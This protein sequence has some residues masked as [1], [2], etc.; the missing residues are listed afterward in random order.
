MKRSGFT[1]IELLVSIGI[2]MLLAGLI[3]S[4]L[5][6]ARQRA[7]TLEARRAIE[8]IQLAW[9]AFLAD[10][11]QFPFEGSGT[12]TLESDMNMLILR[13]GNRN[14][15]TSDGQAYRDLNPKAINYFDI[16]PRSSGIKD[17]WDNYY[18]MAFAMNN[19]GTVDVHGETVRKSV[20]VWSMGPDGRS[21][22]KDD[23]RGW[24]SAN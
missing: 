2:M 10:Y 17:P 7:R 5:N 1:L 8:Q 3:L 14:D 13:G 21:G 18:Q 6:V 20:A 11:H 22:T 15:F 16:H 19:S 12:V 9:N 4:G 23:V 24:R